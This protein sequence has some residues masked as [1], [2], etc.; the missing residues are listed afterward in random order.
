MKKQG[1]FILENSFPVSFS[2]F[3]KLIAK[4]N[5]GLNSY[6][7]Q[8]NFKISDQILRLY[9]LDKN[10]EYQAQQGIPQ[11][12]TALDEKVHDSIFL[13]LRHSS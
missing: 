13:K 2:G 1:C 9:T 10:T 6:L 11:N 3:S 12:E 4:L 8:S 5:T 7:A